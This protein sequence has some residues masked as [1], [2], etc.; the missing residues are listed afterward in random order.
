M[1]EYSFDSRH[2]FLIV[3]DDAAVRD[4]L[5]RT[6]ERNGYSCWLAANAFE[7]RGL[8]ERYSFDLI[9]CDIQMPGE[10]GLEFCRFVRSEYL[11]TAVVMV[12]VIDDLKTAREALSM[13]IYGYAVKPVDT[14]QILINVTNAL[15]RR[16]LEILAK[17][18]QKNLEKQIHDKTAELKERTKQLE[19]LN[20]ALGVLLKKREEDKVALGNQFVTNIKTIIM[21]YLEKIKCIPLSETQRRD[22]E[23][24]ESNIKDIVS[25]FVKEISAT[26][27]GLTAGEIQVAILIKQGKTTKEI[28]AILN[29]SKN[30]IMTHRYK[31][32]TKLGLKNQKCSLHYYLN[33]LQ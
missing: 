24:L 6:L 10:S 30:T 1:E 11:D 17:T 23:L 15:R 33:T 19:E 21:P 22:L 16:E 4:F 7:A 28:A 2:K 13:G 8:L 32:R 14:N 20:S 25:P 29:L 12:T 31:I 18:Y 5:K 9:L 27:F 3:D 26:F